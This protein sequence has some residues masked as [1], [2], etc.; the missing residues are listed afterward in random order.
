M[1]LQM[2][3]ESPRSTTTSTTTTGSHSPFLSTPTTP[4][5]TLST[6][7]VV[8]LPGIWLVAS[9]QHLDPDLLTLLSQGG[10]ATHQARSS[11]IG[12]LRV[13]TSTSGLSRA[14]PIRLLLDL[15]VMQENVQFF[16]VFSSGLISTYSIKNQ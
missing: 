13:S 12:S 14:E 4:L 8:T 3:P 15:C 7:W 2:L 6:F 16:Y 11:W 5:T 9:S 10:R 1:G